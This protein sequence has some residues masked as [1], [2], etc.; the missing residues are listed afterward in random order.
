MTAHFT[1]Q[2]YQA[3]VNKIYSEVTDESAEHVIEIENGNCLLIV[4]VN[5]RISY[6]DEIGGSYEGYDFEMLA[7]VDEEEFDVLSAD[8]FDNEGNEVNSDFDANELYKLLN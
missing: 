5:H 2:D 7:V 3:I 1:T 6:R 8:C 4:E